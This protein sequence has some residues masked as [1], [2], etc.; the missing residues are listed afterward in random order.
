MTGTRS[1]SSVVS[2]RAVRRLLG[3]Q[4]APVYVA[5]SAYHLPRCVLLLRL[6]GLPA[7]PCPAPPGP[8]SRS[9]R[10]RWYWRSRELL[11]L[12]LDSALL[13]ALRLTGRL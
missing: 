3:G 10:R 11:A 6:A 5:S 12:P 13:L 4:L 9:L 1:S 8:A 7:R 2:V